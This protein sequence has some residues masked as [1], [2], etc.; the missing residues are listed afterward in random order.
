MS[1]HTWDVASLGTLSRQWRR[2]IQFGVLMVPLYPVPSVGEEV[3]IRVRCNWEGLAFELTGIATQASEGACVVELK[4]ISAASRDALVRVGIEDAASL[5]QPDEAV[6][7]E[8]APASPPA[9]PP[10]AV[11]PPAAPAPVAAPVV[12]PAASAA[13][14][15]ASAVR[16]P[17]GGLRPKAVAF[18]P[19]ASKPV[20]R[21]PGTTFPAGPASAPQTTAP[22]A[23]APP[24]RDVGITAIASAGGP[25]TLT[26]E[27]LLPPATMHG[28]FSKVSW[29]DVLL[30]FLEN[31]ATGVLAMEAFREIRWCYLVDG[32]PVHFLGDKPHPGEFLSDALQAE[33]SIDAPTWADALRIQQLTGTPAGQVLVRTGKLSSEALRTALHKRAERITRNLMGMNFG[34]FR[35]HEF[36]AIKDAF[37]LRQVDVLAVLLDQQRKALGAIEDDKLVQSIEDYYPLHARPIAGR[38]GLL[39]QVPLRPRERALVDK[40][41]PAGWTL[42]ELVALKELDERSLV[43]LLLALK[44]L[45]MVEFV[46]DEGPDGR[47]N[48]AERKLYAGLRDLKRRSPFEA[49]HSHWSSSEGEIRAGYMKVLNDFSKERFKVVLDGRLEEL[50]DEIRSHAGEIWAL[51]ETRPGRQEQRKAVVGANELQMASDLLDKQG[52]MASFKADFRLVK[53]CYER[54][55]ELDPGT[56][57]GAENRRHAKRWLSDPRVSNVAV[58][59]EL[60]SLD[61]QLDSLL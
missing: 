13:P 12:A 39:K 45:G 16:P 5:P 47:R 30:H 54:V 9:A 55:L 33:G 42:G 24:G 15:P 28:D 18:R 17:A 37:D 61:D 8:P 36:A 2:S 49:L 53:A 58:H 59:G 52:E 4:P 60:S 32:K 48:R 10:P 29:R 14:S 23:A 26:S 46:R 41:L 21:A 6:P 22:G 38:V 3:T 43:R 57:D 7:A 35:F 1:Q 19:K 31:P 27:A 44:S 50:I 56:H 11:P 51:L 40:V 25:A 34:K 20:A